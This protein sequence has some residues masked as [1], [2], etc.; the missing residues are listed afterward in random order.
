M[1]VLSIIKQ[2]HRQVAALIDEADRCEPGDERL[3][4]LARQIEKERSAHLAIEERLF[5]AKLRRARRE[6]RAIRR[7]PS[8]QRALCGQGAHGDAQVPSQAR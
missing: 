5:Y 6:R 8:V 7:V 1:D 4:E 2:E 3:R